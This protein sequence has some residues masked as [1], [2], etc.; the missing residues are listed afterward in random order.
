[1]KLKQRDITLLQLMGM[2]S[3]TALTAVV[4]FYPDL[5]HNTHS[6]RAIEAD[7]ETVLALNSSLQT[8]ER[9]TVGARD[10]L[11]RMQT[12]LEP[13]KKESTRLQTAIKETNFDL[14]LPSILV[15]LEQQALAHDLELV[16]DFEGIQLASVPEPPE[17][18]EDGTPEALEG[19]MEEGGR[20]PMDEADVPL[21]D[22]FEPEDDM[23]MDDP[24]MPDADLGQGG[25][26]EDLPTETPKPV[27]T[28]TEPSQSDATPATETTEKSDTPAATPNEESEDA[29]TP[30]TEGGR[31][32]PNVAKAKEVIPVIPGMDVTTI[33]IRITGSYANVRAFLHYLD[34][35]DFMEHNFI[36]LYSF[37]DSVTGEVVFN[38]FHETKGGNTD[39]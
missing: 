10:A 8:V 9:N 21:E 25:P 38:V 2:A 35:I 32:V 39:E 29:G 1:M 3:I 5:L 4:M 15:A 12:E 30:V 17:V 31:P 24:M 33:P 22:G 11:A 20:D 23:G 34:E 7:K 16:I 26:A 18:P 6:I 19:G 14:H 37:G 27:E 28:E 13:I 36:D